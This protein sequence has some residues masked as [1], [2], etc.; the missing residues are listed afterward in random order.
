MPPW[1][2]AGYE[3][4]SKRMPRECEL[5]LKEIPPGNRTK[6]PDLAKILKEEGERMIAA[7]PSGSHVI[8]LDVAGKTW[9]TLDLAFNLRRWLEAGKSIALLIGGP[10]GLAEAVKSRAGESWSL[11]SLTF[12]HPLVRVIVAE[13]LYRA[14]SIVQNHPYHRQ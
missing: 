10:D 2:K 4:Y 3:E 1:I 11:S 9:T 7:I 13:Q 14:W 6:N 8:A 12:P 5:L